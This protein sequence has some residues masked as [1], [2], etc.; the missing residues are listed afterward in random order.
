MEGCPTFGE[1]GSEGRG[2]R[3]RV[4]LMQ[5]LCAGTLGRTHVLDDRIFSCML[6]G[7]C[8]GRCPAGI[9]ITGAIYAGRATLRSK[10]GEQDMSVT[11]LRHAFNHSA[12]AFR[13][14]RALQGL[15]GSRLFQSL[16][17]AR[18][19]RSMNISLPARSLRDEASVFKVP[20]ARGRVALFAGCTTDY[21]F[22]HLGRPLIE[23]LRALRYDVIMPRGE[24]CCGAPLLSLGFRKDAA[25]LAE[26]NLNLFKKL[27]VEAVISLCPTC[28][29]FLRDEY[30][31][32]VGEGIEYALDD[33]AFFTRH[34]GAMRPYASDG[35]AVYHAPCHTRH[36]LKSDDAAL[37]LLALSG[38]ELIAAEPGCCG[39]GGA[40][41]VRYTEMSSAL[42]EKRLAQFRTAHSIITSCPNCML[43]F[44]SVCGQTGLRHTIE[45]I[46]QALT[47]AKR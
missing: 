27:H 34:A 23:S 3:G 45:I 18:A 11:I 4:A 13:L 9:P 24:S 43:H 37:K 29:Y 44:R 7:A 35:P 26:K 31:N 8:N 36:H 39:F 25:A 33:A 38:R 5:Q 17:A 12:Q 21:L 40:F 16:P 20:N 15:V 22:P 42:L 30:R 1:S 14:L 28:I 19:F 47:G 10:P 46:H 6:C 2:P 41:A 32:L